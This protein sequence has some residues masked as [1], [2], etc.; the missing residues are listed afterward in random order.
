MLF[1]I[2]SGIELGFANLQQATLER[3]LDIVVRDI[4]QGTGNAPQHNEIKDRIC[5]E[6]AFIDDSGTS[7][8]LE[9]VELDPRNWVPISPDPG[10][11]DQSENARPGRNFENGMGNAPM[12]LGVCAKIDP[13]FST[14]GL[15][16]PIPK[17]VPINS[18]WS[19]QRSLCRSRNKPWPR[20]SSP[21]YGASATTKP[22]ARRWNSH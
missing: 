3:A 6:S 10:C 1:L 7:L 19:P 4:R 13:I 15:G 12:V 14:T 5:A 8:R 20:V 22:A 16:M 9:M 21:S 2:C 11:T 18:L 17:T